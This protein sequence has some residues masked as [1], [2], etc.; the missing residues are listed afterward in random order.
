MPFK[1]NH[2]ASKPI[3]GKATFDGEFVAIQILMLIM[4]LGL[5]SW[6]Y[7]LAYFWGVFL[8]GLAA[9]P[10]IISLV[11]TLY[12]LFLNLI[13]VFKRNSGKTKL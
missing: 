2:Y 10:I 11:V 12:S 9:L 6:L 8:F 3:E 4:L 5:G 7:Q 13:K 1:F